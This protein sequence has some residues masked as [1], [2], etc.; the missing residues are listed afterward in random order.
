M[1]I[2]YKKSIQLDKNTIIYGHKGEDAAG[3]PTNAG[4]A[5]LSQV[6]DLVDEN[7]SAN[8]TITTDETDNLLYHIKLGN[9]D[10]ATF[11][12]PKESYVKNVNYLSSTK[13]LQ[14]TVVTS[15]QEEVLNLDLTGAKGD[16]GKDGKSAIISGASATID[17]G[18]GDPEVSVS[19][20]GTDLDRTFSFAFKNLKGVQGEKGAT[21]QTGPQG[22]TGA[23]GDDGYSLTLADRLPY[24][25]TLA[26][27][28]SY[29]NKK[30]DIWPL[31]SFTGK[32]GDTLM[33]PCIITDLGNV[34]GYI[35]HT[36]TAWNDVGKVSTGNNG[37]LIY[38]DKGDTGAKGD[39]G[40]AGPKGETGPQGPVGPQ[41]PAGPT[42]QA[43]ASALGAIYLYTS[44]GTQTNGVA[45]NKVI[46]SALNSKSNTS[47]NHD[48]RYAKGNTNERSHNFR[49]YNGGTFNIPNDISVGEVC[50]YI[51]TAINDDDPEDGR[52]HT[53]NIKTPTAG[54]YLFL[55]SSERVGA[56]T[57]IFS[58][59]PA[60]GSS[61][62][63]KL[64]IYRV[65]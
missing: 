6:L 17:S 4:H 59:N 25:A 46:N 57:L 23:K 14:V 53:F 42:T 24:K 13:I 35:P 1:A 21:G 27:L 2:E 41:G 54:V 9:I 26:V 8:F 44:L 28:K 11:K 15:S 30:N 31:N 56:N 45:N 29:E 10:L 48:G 65:A 12:A 19:L 20:G 60:A 32:I 51:V 34:A 33:M 49:S 22:E 43:T 40:E 50:I 38:G 52:R 58:L 7:I 63:R 3:F 37:Y 16:P 39:T 64:T 55:N 5:P 36:I 61:E 18:T 47:H 62:S